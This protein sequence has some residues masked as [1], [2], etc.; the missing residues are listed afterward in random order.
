MRRQDDQTAR[1]HGI[2]RIANNLCLVLRKVRNLPPVLLV[3]GVA[4]RKRCDDLVLLRRSQVLDGAVREGCALRVAADDELGGR[5]VGDGVLD[6]ALH[7]ADAGEVGAAREEIGGYQGG[8]VDAFD[9]DG[10][11]AEDFFYLVGWGLVEVLVELGSFLGEGKRVMWFGT[12]RSRHSRFNTRAKTAG[13]RREF[14]LV[15]VGDTHAVGCGRPA[16]GAHVADF[17]GAAREE[18]DDGAAAEGGEFVG[19]D[20]DAS[21]L[22]GAGDGEG[23]EEGGGEG[24]HLGGR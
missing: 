17:G 18:H 20:A 5:A 12:H 11:F 4:K 16:D 2:A 13:D 9:G 1:A 22:D 15:R 14:S 10:G 7:L 3:L 19:G 23:E 8:V 21:D 24:L 6:E